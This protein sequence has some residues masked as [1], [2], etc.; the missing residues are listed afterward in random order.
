MDGV[1]AEEDIVVLEAN[2]NK[3][4]MHAAALIRLTFSSSINTA[5]G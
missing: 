2:V 4:S 1:Q 3:T 5:I